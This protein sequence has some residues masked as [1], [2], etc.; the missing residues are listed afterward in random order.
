MRTREVWNLNRRRAEAVLVVLEAASEAV[1]AKGEAKEREA[2]LKLKAAL[3]EAD[4]L[5]VVHNRGEME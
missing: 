2:L 4:Q 3:D 1:Y 5:G